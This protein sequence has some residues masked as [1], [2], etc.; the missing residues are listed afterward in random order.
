VETEHGHLLERHRFGLGGREIARAR[1]DLVDLVVGRACRMVA[2]D[3]GPTARGDLSACAVVATGGYGRQELSPHSDVDVLLLHPGALTTAR[4]AFVESVLPLLWDVGL[5]VGHAVRSIPECVELGRTDVHARN[6]M[7]E[8]RLV[9]GDSELF[10]TFAA[11]MQSSVYR[12]AKANRFFSE[13]MREEVAARRGRYGSVV[14]VLEPN[15]KECAGGLRDLHTIGWVGLARH[16]LMH[17]DELVRAGLVTPSEHRHALR[18][19]DV[20]LRV[21]NE[22]HFQTGRRLDVLSLDLQPSIAAA[23]GYTDRHFASAAELFMRDLYHRAEEILR[24][25]DAFLTRADFWTESPRR[26]P[27]TWSRTVGASSARRYRI[28]DGQ[29]YLRPGDEDLGRDPLQLLEVFREAQR[30]DVSLSAELRERVRARLSIIDRSVRHSP[31]AADAFAEILRDPRGAGRALRGMHET[32]LL[33]RYVPE[34]RRVTLMVQHDQYH[35][36][37]IDEHTL[38]VLEGLDRLS[39]SREEGLAILRGALETVEDRAVLVLAAL[40]HDIGKGRGAGTDHATRGAV[41]AKRVCRRLGIAERKVDDVVFLVQKHLVMS[42]TSQRRDLSDDAVIQGF[43][44]TVETENRLNMLY[45]L[46]YADISGV[47]PGGWNDWKGTL[48]TE[49]YLKS[50]PRVAGQSSVPPASDARVAVEERVLREISPEFLRSD[51]EEFLQHLPARYARALPPEVIASH[52]ELTRQL[53]SRTVVTDWMTSK[54]APYTVLTVGAP[55]APGLLALLAGALTGSGL[56]IL[57]LDV[58]T[59]DDGVALDVFRV[60]EAMGSEPVQRVPESL[61]A[62]VSQS[63]EAALRGDLDVAAAVERQRVRQRRRRKGR[64]ARAPEVRF[65]PTDALGRTPVEV[66]TDDEPGV[67]YRIASTL[68]SLDLNISAAKAA[69]EK[70]QA[71]DIFYVEG[72]DGGPVPDSRHAEIRSALVEVLQGARS[73]EAQRRGA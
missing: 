61:H 52:F 12:D 62:L 9:T 36:Y 17:F 1:A 2:E 24:V 73:L 32:G 66:R 71:L 65:E 46:T 38:H 27:L 43:A 51:V 10:Y 49:L 45:V 58:F 3:L 30:H 5:E 19:S 72:L 29:L 57:S 69:T 40:L 21:R 8:A 59:R 23:M 41:I 16:G 25:S 54:R 70:N 67:L 34:F 22:I 44:D 33:C 42:R 11:D 6:A 39:V 48:L 20:L 56:D 63:L 26:F 64:T 47:A 18:A 14:G 7:S 13:A 50:L 37:T 53:G 31:D 4:V 15:L 68:A 60:G 28:R 35:Q 55:D